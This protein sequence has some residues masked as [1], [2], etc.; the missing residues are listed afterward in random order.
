MPIRRRLSSKARLWALVR[1]KNGKITI[2]IMITELLFLDRIGNKFPFIIIRHRAYQPDFFSNG[3]FC[4]E[5][6]WDLS[7]IVLNDFIGHI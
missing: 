7:L 5:I 4:P 2:G 1:Y 3:I 6:F